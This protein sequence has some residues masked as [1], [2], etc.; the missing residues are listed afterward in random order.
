MM[1]A[2]DR[3]NFAP[4]IALGLH[5][6]QKEF[7][8]DA[9]YRLDMRVDPAAGPCIAS[10][11]ESDEFGYPDIGCSKEGGEGLQA[12]CSHKAAEKQASL[13]PAKELSALLL[14]SQV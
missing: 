10:V 8:V 11:E 13:A 2:G 12:Q 7:I 4:I 3:L 9:K 14:G 5:L 1:R 6:W